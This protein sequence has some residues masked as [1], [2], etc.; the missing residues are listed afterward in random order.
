ME[1]CDNVLLYWPNNTF[2]D[3]L[4]KGTMTWL[5]M[6]VNALILYLFSPY[7]WHLV[8]LPRFILAAMS[9]EMEFITI[10]S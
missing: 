3:H 1:K 8:T 5:D 4:Q 10:F 7:F 2:I 9:D 6:S